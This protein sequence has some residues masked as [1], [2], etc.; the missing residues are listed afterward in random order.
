MKKIAGRP[1]WPAKPSPA[2]PAERAFQVA[3]FDEPWVTAVAPG[4]GG[5]CLWRRPRGQDL[6]DTGEGGVGGQD[7]FKKG[8]P[9]TQK[10]DRPRKQHL[11]RGAG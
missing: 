8:G 10:T 4:P 9:K 11:C 6:P 1:R 2:I 7:E 5:M 3:K